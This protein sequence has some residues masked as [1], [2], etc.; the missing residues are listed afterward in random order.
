TK[1]GLGYM[2]GIAG[3]ASLAIGCYVAELRGTKV[4]LVVLLVFHLLNSVAFSNA[5]PA[6]LA[7]Y[8]R[9]SPP[10]I[11]ATMMGVCYLHFFG[12][13]NLAGFLGGYLETMPGS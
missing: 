7:L 2:V 12:A 5:F 6:A 13:S 8:S 3:L 4:S 9:L 11:A 10:A 1:M